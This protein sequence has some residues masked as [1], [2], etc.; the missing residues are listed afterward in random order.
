MDDDADDPQV[1]RGA[2]TLAEAR[3]RYGPLRKGGCC[4]RII[5]DE[6]LA[7]SLLDDAEQAVVEIQAAMD[8]DG[9]ADTWARRTAAE[10][11]KVREAAAA[12]RKA[13]GTP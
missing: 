10:R 9:D 13:G 5:A 11:A 2:L 3:A 7:R 12:L 1:G 8:P 6:Q 4:W